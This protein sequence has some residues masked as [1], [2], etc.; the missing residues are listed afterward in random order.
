MRNSVAPRLRELDAVDG[1]P[2]RGAPSALMEKHDRLFIGGAWV[3]PSSS[4][5]IDVV[6]P[7]TEDVIAHVAEAREAD[8]DAAVAAARDAFDH[9]PWPRMTPAERAELMTQLL[10][11]L[12][13]RAD[14]LAET[15]TREMGSPISFSRMGQ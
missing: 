3:R 8:I 5:M 11:Q 1:A 7:H 9:G 12:Q 2:P 13:A 4:A 15:I 10:E 6:S 14:D